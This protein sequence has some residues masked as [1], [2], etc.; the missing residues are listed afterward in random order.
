MDNRNSKVRQM[1]DSS[2]GNSRPGG[3]LRQIGEGA[4]ESEK[5]YTVL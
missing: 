1:P 5:Q 4:G 3:S 2:R